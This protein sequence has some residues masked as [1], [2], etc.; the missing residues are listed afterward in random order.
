MLIPVQELV[1]LALFYAALL[2]AW[3]RL[4]IPTLIFLFDFLLLN[5]WLVICLSDSEGAPV[6]HLE[7]RVEF[8]YHDLMHDG[9][10]DNG[11]VL[12]VSGE[13]PWH[14]GAMSSITKQVLADL[15]E[16]NMDLIRLYSV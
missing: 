7:D 6:D 2:F 10:P 3:I 16:S 8:D 5:L 15:C 13:S 4:K 14:D 9:V 1:V 12:P 11:S